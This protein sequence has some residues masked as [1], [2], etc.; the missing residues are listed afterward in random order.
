MKFKLEKQCCGE[1]L[2]RIGSAVSDFERNYDLGHE[3]ISYIVKKVP[4]DI[5]E[6]I[7]IYPESK[8]IRLD[9][10]VP[11]ENNYSYVKNTLVNNDKECLFLLDRMYYRVLRQ[12]PDKK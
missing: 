7:L 12:N 9:K 10:I 11:K 8:D 4:S 6:Y 3:N 2:L 5:A 1:E